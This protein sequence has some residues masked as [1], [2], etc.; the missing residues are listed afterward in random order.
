M[1]FMDKMAQTLNKVGEKTSEVANTTKTKMDIAKVKS[2]VD[3]KYKLLGELVYTALKE[4][5]QPA[6]LGEDMVVDLNA[7]WINGRF[8]TTPESASSSLTEII[9][10][11]GQSSVQLYAKHNLVGTYV[12]S[13]NANALSGASQQLR[14]KSAPATA[15]KFLSTEQTVVAGQDSLAIQVRLV[16]SYGNPATSTSQRLIGLA[17]NGG[18]FSMLSGGN[19]VT[20][21]TAT[22]PAGSSDLTV[23]WRNYRQAGLFSLTIS[24]LSGQALPAIQ[25]NITVTAAA[26]HHLVVSSQPINIMTGETSPLMA[27]AIRDEYGNSQ[28]LPTNV[29]IYLYSTSTTA[30]FSQ[31]A[32]FATPLNN[33]VLPAGSSGGNFY[34]RDLTVGQPI[35]TVADQPLYNP[36][37]PDLGLIDGQQLAEIVPGAVAKFKF[38]DSPSIIRSGDSRLYQVQLQ[39]QYNQ[40]TVAAY[41]LTAYLYT[42]SAYGRFS[43][44]TSFLPTDFITTLNFGNGDSGR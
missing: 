38:I 42:S 23:Y 4:N 24:D 18:D 16:D 3:E 15:L 20:T 43:A 2:N 25:Q 41:P 35:I 5:N 33:F 9:I 37:D 7:N 11:T 34:Y 6:I 12:I 31:S 27:I 10:P 22:V 44:T 30:S 19:F 26:A 21:T 40:P 8:L 29:T 1:S 13:A 39:N 28:V 17:S 32:D 14:I 36:N